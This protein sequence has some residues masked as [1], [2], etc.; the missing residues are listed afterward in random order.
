M[1]SH[2]GCVLI[3]S[4]HGPPNSPVG[5]I[6]SWKLWVALDFLQFIIAH[7]YNLRFGTLCF[8]SVNGCPQEEH[9]HSMDLSQSQEPRSW[10]VVPTCCC[11]KFENPAVPSGCVGMR[12]NTQE[13]ENVCRDFGYWDLSSCLIPFKTWWL[14]CEWGSGVTY[15][16]A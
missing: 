3:L 13:G 6:Y 15:V 4:F 2:G 9:M 5:H 16:L 8:V 12:P 14:A 11:P 7:K 1:G 10:V